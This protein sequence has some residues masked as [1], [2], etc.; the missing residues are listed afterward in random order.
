[1]NWGFNWE[2]KSLQE[3]KKERGN[4]SLGLTK[5]RV[6]KKNKRKKHGGY[7][8]MKTGKL[9]YRNSNIM[10]EKRKPKKRCKEMKI[11]CQMGR[12]GF[13]RQ[14]KKETSGKWD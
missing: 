3:V 14:V 2:G 12:S 7:S 8:G 9:L 10:L 13:G 6:Q 5:N 1:M 4:N 11:K